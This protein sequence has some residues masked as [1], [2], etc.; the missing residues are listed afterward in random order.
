MLKPPCQ[1]LGGKASPLRV[2][3]EHQLTIRWWGVQPRARVARLALEGRT[4]CLGSPGAGWRPGS[5]RPRPAPGHSWPPPPTACPQ[6]ARAQSAAAPVPVTAQPQH[7]LGPQ[8]GTAAQACLAC[9]G[10]T[11][12]CRTAPAPRLPSRSACRCHS[13]CHPCRLLLF[14]ASPM[15]D[16]LTSG[17]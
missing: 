11:L 13:A 1:H 5:P 17:L 3:C 2:C 16:R 10:P 7:T 15:S 6:T 12:S 4:T 9:K 14:G 8:A